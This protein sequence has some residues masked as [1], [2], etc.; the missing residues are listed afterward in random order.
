[1]RKHISVVLVTTVTVCMSIHAR[2]Q[3]APGKLPFENDQLRVVEYVIQAGGKRSLQSHAP[4]LFF[5]VSPLVAT[6]T[7]KDGHSVS[8]SFKVDDPRWYENPI[9]A[10]ANTG[11]SEAKFLIIELK[12]PAPTNHES[13]GGR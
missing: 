9:I 2:S 10:V 13:F 11:K 7:F 3:Q 4:S 1:M 12:K 8:A 5:C 6:L